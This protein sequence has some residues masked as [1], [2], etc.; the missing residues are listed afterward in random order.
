M[1]SRSTPR[2]QGASTS[3]VDGNCYPQQGRDI[4]TVVDTL[5]IDRFALVGW[6]YGALA[7]YA[8]LENAGFDRVERLAILDQTPCPLA[9]EQETTWC[10]GDWSYFMNEFLVPL[11]A[12]RTTFADAFI[13]WMTSRPLNPT[14]REWLAEMHATTPLTAAIALLMSAIFSD[15]RAVA[16]AA[17]NARPVLHV[18]RTEDLDAAV[19]WLRARTPRTHIRSTTSHLSFWQ[20]AEV[21]NEILIG[22]LATVR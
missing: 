21:F 5:G 6:S 19:P 14:D 12:D 15:Y 7:C 13:D 11:A 20:D 1:W 3:T 2:S 10:E 4:G 16:E 22:F 18:V 8:Y 9:R 17:D